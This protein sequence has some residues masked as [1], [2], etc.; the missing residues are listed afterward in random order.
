V[1]TTTDIAAATLTGGAIA[2]DLGPLK[3]ALESKAV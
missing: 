2:R 1:A 3:R